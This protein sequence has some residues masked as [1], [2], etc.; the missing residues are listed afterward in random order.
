MSAFPDGS[1][2]TRFDVAAGDERITTRA[3]F[4]D[5]VAGP[6]DGVT[7]RRTGVE[8]GGH[9][10]NLAIQADRLGCDVTL[11]GHLD[12]PAL[13]DLAFETVSMGAPSSVSI[14]EFDD[15]DLL[16]VEPSADLAAWTVADLA[17]ALGDGLDAF[18]AADAV[19]CANWTSVPG[20]PDALAALADRDVGPEWF[21]VDPADVAG[22]PDDAIARF[23]DALDRLADG[24]DAVLTANPREVRTLAAGLDLPDGDVDAALPGLRET[25]GLAAAVVHG[26]DRAA[27]ATPGGV[28]SVRNFEVEPTRHTG[29]GDRFDAGLASALARGWGWT[30]AL[31][32]GNACASRYVATGETGVA[33]DLAGFLRTHE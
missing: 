3:A 8:P 5:H 23:A 12:D 32:L 27:A 9:A 15:A 13:A 11:V 22:H 33:A 24:V 25:A 31:R 20:L 6:A 2:D 30:D 19:C 29:G 10:V 17:D 7:L 16:A 28:V 1:V 14:H 21:V 26:E 4:A 18:L